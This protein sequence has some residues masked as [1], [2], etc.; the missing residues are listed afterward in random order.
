MSVA[1]DLANHW[2]NM[3]LL[4]EKDAYRSNEGLYLSLERVPPPSEENIFA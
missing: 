1:S 3:V 4:Y 2:T